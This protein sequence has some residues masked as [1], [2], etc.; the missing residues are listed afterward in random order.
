MAIWI[1]YALLSAFFASLVVIFGKLGVQNIDTT[2]ATTVRTIIMAGFLVLLSLF[3]GKQSF[4]NS[5]N[6]KALQ[7]IVL[8]GIAGAVSW[9]F[10]FMALKSGPAAGVVAFDRL[11]IVFVVVLALIFL[12]EK[13]TFQSG[14]GAL[15][16]V[17]GAVLMSL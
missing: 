8:S 10:Y 2:L 11:S 3:L 16:I 17:V 4:L 15:L 6:N 9:L 7:F 14:I 13:I 1:L 5:I 12:S